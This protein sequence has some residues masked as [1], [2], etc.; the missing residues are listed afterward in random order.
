MI[1]NMYLQNDGLA[2]G[3]PLSGIMVE[4]SLNRNENEYIID[5]KNNFKRNIIYYYRYVDDILYLFDGSTR[6][7]T[8]FNK[9]LNNILSSH[10]FTKEI[11]MNNNINYLDLNISKLNNRHWFR[12]YR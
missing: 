2:M 3:S 6:R 10:R 8:N 1:T 7:I 11:E 12:I 9:Y 5:I 4:I